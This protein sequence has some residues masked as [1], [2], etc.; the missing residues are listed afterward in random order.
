LTSRPSVT[1]NDL[2]SDPELA[3]LDALDHTLR[4]AVY[5]LVASYP[6]ITESEIP[7]W[8]RDDSTAGR[9]A[10]HLIACSQKLES[11]LGDYRDA[12]L[13]AR[14]AKVNEELPF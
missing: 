4:L 10:G 7:V 9:A 6:E 11:A 8:R 5:A 13:R 2:R 12:I 3:I 1:P 14:E